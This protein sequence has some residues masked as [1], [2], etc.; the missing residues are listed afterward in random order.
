MKSR[1]TRK[2]RELYAALPR[3]VRQR[4]DYAYKRWRDDPNH[5]GLNFECVDPQESIY[6]AR[7]GRAYRAVCF[8]E[9]DTAV[10]Y[11]I[12]HHNIYDRLLK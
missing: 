7:I 10:W 12:G 2:F 1:T 8:V 5:P 11:W 3:D 9:G 6:S 4:A